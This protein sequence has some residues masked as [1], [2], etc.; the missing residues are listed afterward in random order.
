[1]MASDQ[2][3]HFTATLTEIENTQRSSVAIRYPGRTDSIE[4]NG[5]YQVSNAKI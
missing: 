3:K 1:M 2:V 5:N 4:R